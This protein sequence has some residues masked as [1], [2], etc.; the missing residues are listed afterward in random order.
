VQLSLIVVLQ[1]T[2]YGLP[3]FLLGT[4]FEESEHDTFRREYFSSFSVP[5]K[6]SGEKC[7]ILAIFHDIHKLKLL[8]NSFVKCT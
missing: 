6:G 1:V 2:D 4:V 3:N 5:P 8:K 7:T